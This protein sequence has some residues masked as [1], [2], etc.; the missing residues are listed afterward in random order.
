[1]VALSST[2]L[3]V[4]ESD[5]GNDMRAFQSWVHISG[6]GDQQ[7][8]AAFLYAAGVGENDDGKLMIDGGR[9][10]TY[11]T[12]AY[13]RPR[14]HARR[15]GIDR[16]RDSGDHFF[17]ENADHFVIGATPSPADHYTDVALDDEVY[18]GDFDGSLRHAPRGQPGRGERR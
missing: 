14:Q 3:I 10:G 6:E 9:R 18:T 15:R 11:R 16:R 5:G 12:D 13:C 8:S 1:M 17:G 4:V 7:K 2:N